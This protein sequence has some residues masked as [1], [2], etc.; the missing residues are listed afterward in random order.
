MSR[1]KV[2]KGFPIP[3]GYTGICLPPFG[4]YLREGR[5]DCKSLINHEEIHW[6]Q[7]KEML[8]VFQY[9]LYGIFYVVGFFKFGFK[10]D[11][12]YR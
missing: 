2:R 10:H 9:I 7:S 1:I 3:K 5:Q 11:A 4:I 12:I 8:Y 6:V